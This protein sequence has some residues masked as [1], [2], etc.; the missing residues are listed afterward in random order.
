MADPD[1]IGRAFVNM[2]EA[3][4]YCGDTAGAMTVVREG[5]AE[6]E[7]LGMSET[8]GY[9]L[10]QNGIDIAFEFGDPVRATALNETTRRMDEVGR[11]QYRYGLAQS[12]QFLVASGDATAAE[13]LDE[14]RVRVIGFPVEAQFN[15]PFRV[16]AAERALW[17]DDPT[18]GARG[19]PDRH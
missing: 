8:Y 14:L 19:S 11:Q 7:Q 17:A 12:I 5:I 18:A 13:R 16:A 6:T 15:G 2:S 1:D 3:R 10:A 4:S 9:Y